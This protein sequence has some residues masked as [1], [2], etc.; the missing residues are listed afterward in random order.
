MKILAVIVFIVLAV[1]SFAEEGSVNSGNWRNV[2]VWNCGGKYAV[3][4]DGYYVYDSSVVP[5]TDTC[6]ALPLTV[7]EERDRKHFITVKDG[8]L[9]G[10]RV[11][12]NPDGSISYE[13]NYTDG[14]LDGYFYSYDMNNQLILLSFTVK[15]CK[16][17]S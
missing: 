15:G 6:E 13:A 17:C 10:R 3:S 14:R 1:N 7:G 2:N 12:Y 4:I 11:S 16:K 9:N 8:K 5:V